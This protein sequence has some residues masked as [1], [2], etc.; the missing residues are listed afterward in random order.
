MLAQEKE[1]RGNN[2]LAAEWFPARILCMY[3]STPSFRKMSMRGK[4]NRLVGGNTVYHRSG[5]R[6]LLGTRQ[7]LKTKNGVDPGQAGAWH[8]QHRM[9]HDGPR[10]LCCEKTA[11]FGQNMIMQ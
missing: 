8:H 10:G 11:I 6:G 3:W 2:A 4:E 7:F 9:E 5:S 1:R